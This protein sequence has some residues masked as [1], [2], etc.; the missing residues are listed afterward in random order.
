[1]RVP[2]FQR[3]FLTFTSDDDRKPPRTRSHRA[4]YRF[5]AA[6]IQL[7]CVCTLTAADGAARR[8]VLGASCKS[9]VVGADRDLWLHPNADFCPVASESEIMILK[10]WITNQTRVML[11]PPSLGSQPERQ[12]GLTAD[13]FSDFEVR[14]RETGGEV[15]DSTE[16][17]IEATRAQRPLVARLQYRDAGYRVR[18]DHPVKTM[19]V[20][21]R[22]GVFQTDTGP[23]LLPDFTREREQGLLVSAFELAFA[24]FNRPAFAEMVIR[25]PTPVA[26]GAAAPAVPAVTAD[27]YEATRRIEAMDNQVL[28]L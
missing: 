22:D 5:N 4:P 12:I 8:Y 11:E 18:I 23:V 24:A 21:P 26:G 14:V 1:M 2:D 20:N 15:L 17:I 7:E 19:N 16:R 25:R 13:L 27:Y 3:S 28:A 10:S 6:R 9:E